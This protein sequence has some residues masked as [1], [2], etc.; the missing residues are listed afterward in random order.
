MSTLLVRYEAARHALRVATQIDEVKDIRDKALALAEYARQAKDT[1]MLENVK[2]LQLR[3]ERRLGEMLEETE[4][5]KG[6]RPAKSEIEK[7]L[8][9]TPNKRYEPGEG[10]STP[11]LAE[12]GLSG[13]QS[14]DFQAIA[15]IAEDKFEEILATKK[16]T[17]R[18]LVRESPK[19]ANGA[20]KTHK[21]RKPKP[22]A[23]DVVPKADYDKLI[24]QYNVLQEKCDF[25]EFSLKSHVVVT[26]GE[27]ADQ[28]RNLMIENKAVRK[29]RDESMVKVVE[30][31]R[32]VKWW[33]KEC[34]KLGWKSKK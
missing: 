24:E 3:A 18:S 1:E 23:P 15:A 9:S 34:E 6:G 16:P 8:N 30:L 7:A 17:T 25:I 32:Q 31:E 22:P 26:N 27:H 33:R 10:F 4:R 12:I 2:K 28:L 29:A 11:T 19:K 5:A 13:K 21:P 14:S 20:A